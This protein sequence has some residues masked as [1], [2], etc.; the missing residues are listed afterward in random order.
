M[1]HHLVIKK[2]FAEE[3]DNKDHSQ[4]DAKDSMVI[5]EDMEFSSLQYAGSYKGT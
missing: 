1:H 5:D 4:H 2:L 3:I